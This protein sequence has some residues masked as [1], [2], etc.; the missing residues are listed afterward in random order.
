VPSHQTED[1]FSHQVPTD[2]SSSGTSRVTASTPSRTTT[3]TIGSQRSDSSQ[4]QRTPSEDNSSPQSDGTDILRSGTTKPSTSRT[5]SKL[6][7][8]T[9]TPSPFHQEETTSS[10][11]EKT[12]KSEFSISAMLKSQPQSTMPEPQSTALAFNPRCHWIAIGTEAGWQIWD[13]EAKDS[14]IIADGE[15]KLE[16]PVQAENATKKVKQPKYHS[17]TSIAW[18]TL[19]TRLFV[20]FS[21]GHIKVYDISEQRVN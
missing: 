16:K 1:T 19:G 7:M 4:P 18:N 13:F 3:T 14:P 21:N 11:V 9:S 17:V 15:F 6:T 10:P 20:G 5:H 2:K 12:R 8:V